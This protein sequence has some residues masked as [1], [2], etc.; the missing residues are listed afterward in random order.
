MTERTTVKPYSLAEGE[1]R[2]YEWHDVLFTIKAAS[3]ETGGELSV[4]EVTTRK[5]KEPE[6]HMHDEDE[7]FYVL[8]GSVTFHCGGKDFNV[9]ENGFMFL[10]RGIPHRYTIESEEA[11][12]LGLSTPSA[13]GDHI[14][15]TGKLVKSRRRAK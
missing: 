12:L 15:R 9:K 14:E 1:G 10:P 13:F 11:R 2:T 7:I 8:A 4:W 5:G 6:I 3:V